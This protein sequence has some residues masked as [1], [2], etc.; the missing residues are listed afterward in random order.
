[1]FFDWKPTVS[2]TASTKSSLCIAFLAFALIAGWSTRPAAQPPAVADA[3]KADETTPA[4][5]TSNESTDSPELSESSGDAVNDMQSNAIREQSAA[6]GH[7]GV[8]ASKYSSWT[9]HSNRLIPVY[10]FGIT[11]DSLRQEGSVY[12]DR[13]RLEK[14]YGT[15]TPGTHQPSADYFDQ[16][17]VYRL[18]QQAIA[19][20]KKNIVLFVFDGMDWQTTRA[21]ALYKAG[22]VR[23]ERGRGTG[24]SFQDYRGVETDYGLVVTSPRQS[25]ATFDVDAQTVTGQKDITGGY[26]PQRGGHTPAMEQSRRSYLV[27]LE[28]DR[29]HTVTDSAAS[30]T[31]L[32]SGIK[33][34]NGAIGVDAFGQAV[35]SIAHQLQ[36]EKGFAIGMVTS[37]PVSHAT[38]ASAYANN[39][40][41]KDY[42][43]ISRDLLGLPSS[44]HRDAPNQGV[45]VLI[46]GGYGQGKGADK[47][48][49]S[50]FMPGNT[51]LHES[52]LRRSDVANGGRYVVAKRTKD[53]DGADVLNEAADQAVKGNH[54]LVGFFGG[55]GGHLP[56]Q[57]ADGDYK[58]TFDIRGTEKYS[59][60]DIQENPTLAEMATAALKVLQQDPDGFWLMIEAGD[61]DW[62]NH[63]NNL[64]N[65]IGAVLSGEAAFDAVVD[66]VEKNDAWQE[67]AILLTA[68]H[69]HYLVIEAPETIAAAGADKVG[70]SEK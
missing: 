40:T 30:A 52:D 3:T 12:S 42:Q 37:V 17:D 46:G 24:L 2:M 55:R 41:R 28:R 5:A 45:D 32:C 67:T 20:G 11:L 69:G 58:P 10:T 29:E 7:W 65:S 6:W 57:T 49:G 66:W 63:A 27:G 48:Q 53:R 35:E 26:D 31:S 38:P 16:T 62:A 44:F 13:E 43:D 15:V 56:F 33:T 34:Y 54:R 4:E 21:A 68:D 25:G 8:D 64:D 50:N 14:L 70:K 60:A 9:N 36:R 39:V 1:M 19:A 18:Q 59:Q 51:Y 47:V 61:V 22:K 23:Y